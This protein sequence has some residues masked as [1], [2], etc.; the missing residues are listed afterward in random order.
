MVQHGK[1]FAL[2]E[3]AI[4]D[5][6]FVDDFLAGLRIALERSLCRLI[7]LVERLGLDRRAGFA[8]HLRAV[9]SRH[10]VLNAGGEIRAR[11]QCHVLLQW[12]FVA[13]KQ[14]LLTNKRAGV[15]I[16]RHTNH[17][18]LPLGRCPLQS[19]TIRSICFDD[20]AF[21][22]RTFAAQFER[23]GCWLGGCWRACCWQY[24]VASITAFW[25]G[26][27]FA[28]SSANFFSSSFF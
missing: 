26:I 6:Q 13:A 20:R 15:H 21:I 25:N 17:E 12:R 5:Q 22:R 7:P 19:G 8:A 18:R 24:R 28:R 4:V 16:L 10:G 9:C 3:R 2:S 1:H 14:S 27:P 23:G 11:R